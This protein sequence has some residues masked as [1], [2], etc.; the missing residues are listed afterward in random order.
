MDEITGTLKNAS[1]D[2]QAKVVW[3]WLYNDI[4]GRWRDGTRIHTSEAMSCERDDKPEFIKT[5][6]SYYQVEWA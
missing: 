2:P 3:G 1:W 6:N 5:R 4:H